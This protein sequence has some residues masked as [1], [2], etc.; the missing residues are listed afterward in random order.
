MLASTISSA[1][2]IISCSL[3]PRSGERGKAIRPV[4]ADS[5]IPKGA[6]SFMNE[7]TREGF[8]ELDDMLVWSQRR[9]RRGKAYTS[10]IQLFVL[11]SKI[12]PPN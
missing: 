12:F 11:M 2:L 7:S 8:A 1:S 4:R 6:M 3:G 9:G 5:R 10:T